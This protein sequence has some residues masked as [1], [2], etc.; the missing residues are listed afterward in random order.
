MAPWRQ[1]GEEYF[2]F[3]SMSQEQPDHIVDYNKALKKYASA[4]RSEG[5]KSEALL[6]VYVLK[7][8]Q[9]K[10]YT[11]NRQR[12]VLNYIADFICKKLKLII[13]LDGVTHDNEEVHVKD[14]IKTN[15]LASEGYTILRFTDA[16]VYNGID[17]VQKEI[18]FA[19]KE[20]ERNSSL[21]LTS[22]GTPSKRET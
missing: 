6:W 12:P 5:T 9:M 21:P 22:S 18:E 3:C 13:E 10:G 7:N 11:F 4:M 2:L 17:R 15:E 16:E 1:T 8:K 14:L 20:I 19:I